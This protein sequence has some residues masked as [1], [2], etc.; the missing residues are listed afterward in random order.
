[1]SRHFLD[2]AD[3]FPLGHASVV[4]LRASRDFGPLNVW[5]D[6]FNLTNARYAQYGYV[7]TGFDGGA[8][9][10]DYPGSRFAARVGARWAEEVIRRS[11]DAATEDRRCAPS[12][13]AAG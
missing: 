11:S 1:M 6:L 9:P 7:L 4:D 12:G 13:R 3:L 8:V 5:L 2:D 10:Y